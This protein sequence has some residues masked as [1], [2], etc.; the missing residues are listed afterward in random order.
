[1]YQPNYTYSAVSR[2]GGS[3]RMT[4]TNKI[5]GPN[6][7]QFHRQDSNSKIESPHPNLRHAIQTNNNS[8]IIRPKFHRCS[9]NSSQST[10]FTTMTHAD[11]CDN[12]MNTKIPEQQQPPQQTKQM[13]TLTTIAEKL[14]RGTRKVFQ[15]TQPTAP[16]AVV[17]NGN[18][19]EI[20]ETNSNDYSL[21][22]PESREKLIKLI[23]VESTQTNN[24][25]SNSSLQELDEDMN[26]T[27]LTRFMGE[28]NDEIKVKQE[29]NVSNDIS[30]SNNK[31]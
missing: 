27:E 26:S 19:P 13:S 5:I 18:I 25:I 16:N 21:A 22:T 12:C 4:Q 2:Y 15:F 23:S 11:A 29:R 7:S 30:C 17:V 10:I 6:N 3:Q 20:K 31:I 1:M 24:T 8:K 14:R 28:I 9:S